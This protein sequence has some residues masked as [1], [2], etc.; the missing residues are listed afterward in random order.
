MKS[1][2]QPTKKPIADRECPD[3]FAEFGCCLGC[4]EMRKEQVEGLERDVY[5]DGRFYS[6]VCFDCK[7]KKC[8]WYFER[9]CQRKWF[10][11]NGMPF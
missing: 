2:Y 8:T 1:S 10:M 9:E 11:E 3:F 6:C 7:C 5:Y 4:D